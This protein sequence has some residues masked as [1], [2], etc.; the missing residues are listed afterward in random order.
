MSTGR[1][2]NEPG[3]D[4]VAAV[5]RTSCISAV[6]PAETVSNLVEH[7]KPLDDAG[8]QIERRRIAVVP[9]DGE[10]AKIA[11]SL[12]KATR[13]AGL[14]EARRLCLPGGGS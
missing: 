5:L 2:R 4:R 3:A 1:S 6:N 11:A 10:Q 13:F 14:S 12:W 7:G 9:F 8:Y